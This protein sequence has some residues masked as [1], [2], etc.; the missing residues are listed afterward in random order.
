[1]NVMS[2]VLFLAALLIGC[3]TQKN[4]PISTSNS[5]HE[6]LLKATASNFQTSS[7]TWNIDGA[8][9]GPTGFTGEWAMY[10]TCTAGTRVSVTAF[11]S[12]PPNL[13]NNS[14][15]PKLGTV[16]AAIQVDGS[17]WQQNSSSG[18]T[19]NTTATGVVP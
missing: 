15:Q 5:T 10:I 8:T 6:V 7:V 12:N 11:A 14:N 17:D 16:I 3:E 1:M 2:V 18:Q 13:N 9:G 19:A 4:N